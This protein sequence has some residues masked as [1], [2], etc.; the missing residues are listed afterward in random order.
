MEKDKLS[1]IS[2]ILILSIIMINKL[3]LNVPYFI[4]KEVGSGTIINLIYIGII[5]YV[6]LLIILKLFKKFNTHDLIDIA[7]FLGGKP[8]KTIISIITI[9]LFL[10]AAFI[11][12]LDFSNVLHTIYF[13]NFDM[14]YILL[15][16]I[17]GIIIANLLGLNSIIG[18]SSFISFFAIASIMITFINTSSNFSINNFTPILGKNLNTTFLNGLVNTFTMY[19]IVYIYFLKPLLNKP[20][21]FEKVSKKSFIVSFI[22]LIIT[23][24]S[25]MSLFSGNANT[26]PINSLFLLARQIEFGNFLQRIDALFIFIWILT[27]F[28]YLSFTIYMILK[29]FKKLLNI[30]DEKMLT[31]PICS[32]L[33]GLTLIPINIS[34]IHFIEKNIY[35]YSIIIYIFGIAFF[36][37][38]FGYIKKMKGKEI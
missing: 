5:D 11:T 22:I 18:F 36:T 37:L 17:T 27:I 7:E 14:I 38:L 8:L 26:E 6:F 1:N 30:E 3:I 33:L 32:I 23:S 2:A 12:I 9:L 16:F 19:I 15:F 25:M 21:D 24:I 34:T 29:I 4:I 20:E 28:A 31:Y 35:S 10:L 13:S